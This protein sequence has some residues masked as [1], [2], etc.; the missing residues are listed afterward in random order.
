MGVIGLSFA[1]FKLQLPA[2]R[3]PTQHATPRNTPQ[4]TNLLETCWTRVNISVVVWTAVRWPTSDLP[5]LTTYLIC[6]IGKGTWHFFTRYSKG[7]MRSK[8]EAV[9]RWF[10]LLLSWALRISDVFMP[11]WHCSD[12]NN[13]FNYCQHCSFNFN[14]SYLKNQYNIIFV[15][16]LSCIQY[17]IYIIIQTFNVFLLLRGICM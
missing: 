7:K 17:H 4:D 3:R 13:S 16:L 9:V 12:S 14:I 2:T 15:R 1:L 8:Y 5:F 10:Y 6:D 11:T